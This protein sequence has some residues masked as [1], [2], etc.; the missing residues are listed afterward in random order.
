V[1]AADADDGAIGELALG[2][3]VR[4]EADGKEGE[5]VLYKLWWMSQ[6][7]VCCSPPSP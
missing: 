2:L 7:K 3:D 6:L 1:F 4:R 5:V